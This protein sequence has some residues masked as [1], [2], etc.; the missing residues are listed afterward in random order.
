MNH[1]IILTVNIHPIGGMQTYVAGKAKFLE[2]QGWKVNVFFSGRSNNGECAVKSLNKYMEGW[3]P[4]ISVPPGNWPAS[5]RERVLRDMRRQIGDL[6]GTVVVESQTSG[7]ALWGELLASRIGAKHFFFICNEL[8]RGKDRFYMEYMKF[9]DFKHRRKEMIGS[10]PTSIA[11][12]FEG[13]K[14]IP[15]EENYF[16]TP[17]AE[18]PVQDVDNLAVNTIERADWNICYIGRIEKGYVPGIVEG[19]RNFSIT[20]PEKSVQFIFVGNVKKR[21]ELIEETFSNT[22]NVKLTYLGDCVPIP[23]SLFQ[24]LDVVIAGAGCATCAARE[25]VL[26]IVADAG[27]FRANG[28]L[29]IDTFAILYHEAEKEQMGFDEALEKVLVRGEY[30]GKEIHGLP[31]SLP[32]EH[33]YREQLKMIENSDRDIKYY[34]VLKARKFSHKPSW[35]YYRLEWMVKIMFRKHVVG[36]QSG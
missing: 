12:L 31:N 32:C 22:K 11:L 17:A 1:Y 13:N 21:I 14:H 20:H 30:E 19:V 10:T 26:T 25:N 23:R 15:P 4:E 3:F 18:E 28:V 33:Y 35:I 8:F 7:N 5:I 9:F 6:G 16:T 24:K 29:G 2:S 34:D 36:K 27:N